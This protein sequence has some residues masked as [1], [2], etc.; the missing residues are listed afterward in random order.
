MD[1]TD[2]RAAHRFELATDAGVAFAAYEL[3]GDTLTFTHTVVPEV[4]EGHG[5]GSHLIAGA[6]AQVRDAGLKV[7]ARCPFVAAY[8]ERHPEWRGLLKEG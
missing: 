5:V 2:N 4:A 1:V 6:L 7:V 8:I 3:A